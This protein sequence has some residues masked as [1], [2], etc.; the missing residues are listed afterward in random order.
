VTNDHRTYFSTWLGNQVLAST[1]AVDETPAAPSEPGASPGAS[2]AP[3]ASEAP[4]AD[5][6]GHPTSFVL[7][8]ATLARTDFTQPDV[9]L[10]VVDPTGQLVTYWAGTLAG[11]DAAGWT[12]GTGQLVLDRW[13]T[14][15]PEP[16]PTSEPA[17]E[18][19]R[20]GPQ[21]AAVPIDTG[22]T[23]AFKVR[24]DPDGT[25]LAVWTAEQAGDAVGRL[26]LLVIDP[27]I[28]TIRTEA[29]PLAAE[30]ALRR[31]SI[32]LGRL[33]WVSPS[34]Q[35][36]QQSSVK[37]LG[38]SKDDFGEIQTLPARDLFIVR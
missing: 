33:A 3:D 12:L 35:D 26:S 19:P 13:S 24:F 7:D 16:E 10:P 11:D 30:P 31:F 4:D 8:P 2:G 1:I 32:D 14:E 37:V 34:G 5:A 27:E 25:R 17:G 21:G 6:A 23:G 22:R 9:W 28:G 36:G 18:G 15:T 38:W 29:A 20:F